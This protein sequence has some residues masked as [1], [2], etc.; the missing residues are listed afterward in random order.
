MMLDQIEE[1]Q[2][3]QQAQYKNDPKKAKTIGVPTPPGLY[4]KLAQLKKKKGLKSLKEAML[5]AAEA[6]I[7]GLL[8]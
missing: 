4:A 7:D 8:R 2:R 3:K 6:G 5:L 1:K